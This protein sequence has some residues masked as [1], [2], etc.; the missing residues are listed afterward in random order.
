MFL[1]VT[2]NPCIERTVVIPDFAAGAR[3][4]VA[5]Q[6]LFAD[7]GG[8][9]INAARVAGKFGVE[10]LALTWIGEHQ[11][12]WFESE[13]LRDNVPHELVE[14]ASDTRVCVNILDGCG[15][16][17]EV[18]E[19]GNPLGISDGT[20][21]LERF[22]QL[23]PRA[24]LVAICGSYPSAAPENETVFASHATLLCRMAHAANVRV[25]LDSKGAAFSVALND[26]LSRNTKIWCIKPNISEAEE[27][28]QR[29]ILSR[30]AEIRA[31]DELRQFAK[32]VLLSCG[33]L[34]CYLATHNQIFFF[35]A[36]QIEALSP[37]GSGDSLVGAFA[38][39]IL[40]GASEIEALRWGV[41]AGA[42]NAM[43]VRAGFCTREEIEAL[44]GQ[45]Q[46]EEL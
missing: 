19:A 40:L 10:T 5:P 43:Q 17:T 1:T 31:L 8:K 24:S 11:R 37:V 3:H 30:D 42:A 32:N 28:F 21:L 4:R 14:T 6:D 44:V 2:P 20:R 9:G 36:P 35:H 12:A 39:K 16:K 23:L 25:I 38:A 34:G 15:G 33:E 7:A 41:S 13:L 29:P 22:A 45:V 26:A 27:F 18:V 46:V